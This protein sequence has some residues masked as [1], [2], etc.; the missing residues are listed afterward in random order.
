MGQVAC[1]GTRGYKHL[2]ENK[3]SC[4]LCTPWCSVL[5]YLPCLW[6]FWV[7]RNLKFKEQDKL[8]IMASLWGAQKEIQKHKS[9]LL[10]MLNIRTNPS[11]TINNN[12]P[13]FFS[14]MVHVKQQAEGNMWG[15]TWKQMFIMIQWGILITLTDGIKTGFFWIWGMC[16]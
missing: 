16:W 12:I 7:L 2:S 3:T 15:L 1:S 4:S 11:W 9:I 5:S 8:N 10:A 14:K 13:L 6:L